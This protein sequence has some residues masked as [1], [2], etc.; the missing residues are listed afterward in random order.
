MLRAWTDRLGWAGV[1]G[2]ILWTLGPVLTDWSGSV[3][4][5][6]GGIDAMFQLGLLHWSAGHWWQPAVWLDLPIFYPLHGML[7]CMDSLLGQAW[8]VWPVH[9]AVHPTAAALYNLAFAGS[10]LL[11]AAGMAALWRASRGVWRGAGVAALAL[12]GAPY[13]TAQLGH[14][15]QL[16]PPF[17]L[18]CLTAVVMALRRRDAGRDP[19]PWWWLTGASLVLQAAWG[20]Y[21]FAYALIGTAVLKIAWLVRRTRA[22]AGLLPDL[23]A[24]LRQ[25]GLPALVTV[26]AVYVLAQPQ[27]QLGR[28]YPEFTRSQTEVR[29]GS[30]D[31]QHLWNRGAYRGR[32]S[33]WLGHGP[34]AETRYR[35]W[36]RQT[37]HPGWI[38]LLLALYGWRRR[39]DPTPV[40]AAFGGVL[41]IM[42]VVGLVL[43]FGDSVG[44]PGTGWR[45][46]L[47]LEWLRAVAPPFRAF[48]GAWRFVWL[49]TIAVAW[50]AAAGTVALAA[51][52]GWRRR[53]AG[54]LVVLMT[55]MS[56]PM[57][58]PALPV[59]LPGRPLPPDQRAAGPVLTLPAPVNE[60]AENRTEALW[61]TRAQEL[62]QPVTGGATGWVP[63]EAA[64]LRSEIARC[65][66]NDSLAVRFLR[67]MRD[68]GVA[69]AEVAI[70][71]G[72][73]TTLFW[74]RILRTAG[75]GRISGGDIPGYERYRLRPETPT[76]P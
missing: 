61:L 53:L 47:P 66:G 5:P 25:A 37:L 1:A 20:W 71:A 46:P 59:P 39:G 19:R 74:R 30:A 8:L 24:T 51:A 36:P 60:Y 6:F 57:G 23:T 3:L 32:V 14:L 43:A 34:D 70:A 63:P 29:L 76:R 11:A 31:I 16:P 55:L 64:A 72:D 12:V 38:A 26:L 33:D 27:L 40:R 56:L 65:A 13:T 21:G 44:V 42:G 28:R 69:E 4:G 18:F 45:L 7:G 15:N 75:A 22:G 54:P 2:F 62:G 58:V 41:L 68:R 48:R 67:R 9:L 52:T 49:M 73:T 10:L 17:V 35:G 50:W